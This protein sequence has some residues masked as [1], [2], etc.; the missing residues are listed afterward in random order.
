MIGGSPATRVGSRRARPGTG[1]ASRRSRFR[2]CAR[3]RNRSKTANSYRPILLVLA[4]W[5]RIITNRPGRGSRQTR[6]WPLTHPARSFRRARTC[7]PG[8]RPRRSCACVDSRES[9]RPASARA[10]PLV[11]PLTQ[12]PAHDRG[13]GS[14]GKTSPVDANARRGSGA[15]PEIHPGLDQHPDC[16]VR[17][18]V[19]GRADSRRAV[20]PAQADHLWL[21]SALNTTVTDAHGE[22]SGLRGRPE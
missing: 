15:R 22:T 6:R 21:G 16:L 17:S 11:P 7:A 20:G 4:G 10:R 18:G 12:A 5:A 2:D 8:P 1:A 9:G 14:G 3:H 19:R 13:E